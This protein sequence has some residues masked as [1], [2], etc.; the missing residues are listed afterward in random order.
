MKAKS[1]RPLLSLLGLS[2]LLAAVL[3]LPLI[4]TPKG[5][6]VPILMYH[7][8]DDTVASD[9]TMTPAAFEAHLAALS[10]AGYT[11]V[12]FQELLDY[13]NGDGDLPDR[14]VCITIDDGYLSNY[15]VA[16]PLLERYGMKATIF[17]IGSSVGRDHYKDTGYSIIPHFSWAQAEE[18]LASGTVDIQC[19]TYDM[20]QYAPYEAGAAR[21]NIL[22]LEGESEADY[23]AALTADTE[24]FQ[25]EYEA[26][27]G[28]RAWVLAYPTG[29][30]SDLSEK[31]LHALG[32]SVTLTTEGAKVNRILPGRPE[33]LYALGRHDI[34]EAVTP[35]AL[36]AMLG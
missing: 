16:W 31:V 3:L 15:T 34:T 25:A 22:P 7:H 32:F 36:L 35:D 19:H 24:R 18:M 4:L 29:V 17:V 30:Y 13:V 1:P 33:S 10:Q 11:A 23:T 6:V 26:A 8:F 12:T 21:P 27:L 2:L 14:P 28:R 9:A 20:H 5:T